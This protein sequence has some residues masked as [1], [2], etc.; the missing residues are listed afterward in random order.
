MAVCLGGVLGPPWRFPDMTRGQGLKRTV[1]I[2]TSGPAEGQQ[3][4]P[5]LGPDATPVPLLRGWLHAVTAPVALIA[6][7]VLVALARTTAAAM[8]A[9]AYAVTAVSL[10]AVSALYHRGHWS[11]RVKLALRR[12]DHAN[13]FLFIAGTYTPFAVLALRGATR[14]VVL[15]VVWAVAVAGVVFRALWLGAPRW[16]YVPAYLGLGWTAAFII[17][18]LLRGAGVAAFTLIAVGGAAYTAG[19]IVYG[20]RRPNLNRRWFGFHELF[21]LCTIVAFVC[22]YVAA[23]LV[24]YRAA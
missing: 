21:H 16:L 5:L 7:C 10:F 13:A 2:V 8:A 17:P 24:T 15:A 6:G 23:S 22:Q 1:G 18:Q 12:I 14:V 9:A 11:P 3:N 20:L 4:L 19:A